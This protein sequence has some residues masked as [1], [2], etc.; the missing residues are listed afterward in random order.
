M[1]KILF[2][3]SALILSMT[4]YSNNS[5]YTICIDPGHQLKGNSELEEQAPGSK[6]R[7]VKVSSGTRGVST[8]IN[9]YQLNLDIALKLEK[10]LTQKGYK[11]YMTRKTNNVNISNKERA[12]DTNKRGCS[13]YLRLHADGSENI[14]L[15][16]ASVLTSSKNNPYTR[17][18]QK[19]SEEFSK[20][21]LEEYVKTTGTK[22]RGIQYRDDL[23][24]TNWSTVTNSLIEMGFMSNPDEDILMS[25]D[26]YRD[27]I[28]NGITNGIE[29]YLNKS[30]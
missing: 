3:L 6:I 25:K 28:V 8:K 1:K 24:G 15:K 29:K 14:S 26:S 11:V 30:K 9:E 20:I 27:K 23:T 4:S 21:L 18:V 13:V 22:N 2:L 19:S 7:K 17:K 12:L 10:K 16:G 5:E